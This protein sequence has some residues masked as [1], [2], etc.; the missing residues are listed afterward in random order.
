MVKINISNLNEGDVVYYR[1]GD[2]YKTGEFVK[3][4]GDILDLKVI[5]VK[6]IGFPVYDEIVD[7]FLISKDEYDKKSTSRK[8]QVMSD[9]YSIIVDKIKDSKPV[10]NMKTKTPKTAKEP[11]AS[12]IKTK[13]LIDGNLS[14]KPTL[15]GLSDIAEA[16]GDK[17]Y[18]TTKWCYYAIEHKDQTHAFTWKNEV[19]ELFALYQ[20]CG[21]EALLKL[22]SFTVG[23]S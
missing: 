8:T 21:A 1:K 3:H 12:K 5:L 22:E 9:D 6:A 14:V 10:K 11:K 15:K 20:N 7:G 2:E 18:R 23:A 4:T 17:I 13:I 19:K 16:N